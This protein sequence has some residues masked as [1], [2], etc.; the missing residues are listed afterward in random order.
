MSESEEEKTE[1]TQHWARKLTSVDEQ[2]KSRCNLCQMPEKVGL[3]I[4]LIYLKGWG[5]KTSIT[6]IKRH[7]F[8]KHPNAKE[9]VQPVVPMTTQRQTSLLEVK[10][11]LPHSHSHLVSSYPSSFHYRTF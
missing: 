10:L 11:S 2:G 7:M 3:T 9:T 4:I 8:K 5:S 6:T 1:P